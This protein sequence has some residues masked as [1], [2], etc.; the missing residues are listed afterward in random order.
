MEKGKIPTEGFIIKKIQSRLKKIGYYDN[1]INGILNKK[2]FDAIINFFKEYEPKIEK[3]S[4]KH[5]D[6]LLR[7]YDIKRKIE[8]INKLVKKYNSSSEFIFSSNPGLAD[9]NYNKRKCIK[10]PYSFDVVDTNLEYTYEL[11]KIDLEGLKARYPFMEIDVAGKSVLGRNIYYIKLGR[12]PKQVFYNGAHHALEWITSSLLVKFIEEFLKAYTNGNP[13]SGFET[14]KI[15]ETTTI[16]IIPMVNPDG[17]DLV[18]NGVDEKCSYYKKVIEWNGGRNDFSKNWQANIRGVDLNHNY[19]ASWELS[20]QA[21]LNYGIYGP[22][23][24]R[25]SG[26]YPESEPETRAV[27]NFTRNH[28]FNMVLAFHSQGEVIYWNYMDMA[29]KK[30]KEYGQKLCNASGYELDETSGIA[31]YSGFK[32]WFIERYRRPGYTIEVGLGINPLP[33]EKF[34]KIYSDNEKLLLLAATL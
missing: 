13:L 10:V 17:V 7:G 31:S 16:Y 21:E 5:F 3:I 20:S 33:L 32:D 29:T 22:G 12:G 15:W 9:K 30:A 25:H 27:A 8:D 34:D 11:L 14:H 28:D 6:K 26:A 2:T 4:K 23:P 24:T 19:D 18:I 1:D